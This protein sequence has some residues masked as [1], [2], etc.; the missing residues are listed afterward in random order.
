MGN[1]LRDLIDTY[2]KLI[3]EPNDSNMTVDREY[4]VKGVVGQVIVVINDN[5]SH[6]R[7]PYNKFAKV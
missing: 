5:G 3:R 4:F 6:S 7:V 1:S 2:I